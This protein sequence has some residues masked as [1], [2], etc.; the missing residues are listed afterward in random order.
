MS[1]EVQLPGER[2]RKAFV[3]K[4]GQF[5]SSL[6]PSE[7]QMLD[8]MA[9]TAFQP[10]GQR[11]VQGY[12]WFWSQT[13]PYGPGWYNTGWQYPWDNTPYSNTAYSLYARPD[14]RYL[15]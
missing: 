9:I 14:G 15:P 12:T 3:E 4:L 6:P 2:E 1:Q 11:E 7:Q 10:Q 13:G 5:R 8:I